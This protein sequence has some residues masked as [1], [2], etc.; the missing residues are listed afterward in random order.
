MWSE[1]YKN[2]FFHQTC[3]DAFYES[4]INMLEIHM[5]ISP[6]GRA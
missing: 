4:S 2:G 1:D 6:S 5:L 3:V